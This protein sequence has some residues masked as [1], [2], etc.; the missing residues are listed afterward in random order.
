M[1]KKK[2]KMHNAVT[3]S[4]M[5]LIPTVPI[6]D[7]QPEVPAAAKKRNG[8]SP[9]GGIVNINETSY[10]TDIVKAIFPPILL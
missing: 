4:Q 2:L 3:T 7:A 10:C 5:Y 6:I 8:S 1:L 9:A